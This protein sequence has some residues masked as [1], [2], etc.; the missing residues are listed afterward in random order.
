MLEMS[1]LPTYA[2]LISNVVEASLNYSCLPNK[3]EN[4]NQGDINPDLNRDLNC[5][6]FTMM[7]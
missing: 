4:E 1:F 3:V 2:P 6:S 7:I 5:A